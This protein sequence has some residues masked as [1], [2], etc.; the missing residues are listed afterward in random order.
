MRY[1]TATF[2]LLKKVNSKD[3]L[4]E[5]FFT[6]LYRILYPNTRMWVIADRL[7]ICPG[8]KVRN[9]SRRTGERVIN[10]KFLSLEAQAGRL[11]YRAHYSRFFIERGE[12]PNYKKVDDWHTYV[13]FDEVH[14]EE[15]L[16]DTHEGKPSNEPRSPL[17]Q[18]ESKWQSWLRE[19][20]LI[21]LKQYVIQKNG[22]HKNY[23]VMSHEFEVKLEQFIRGRNTL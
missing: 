7:Q 11:L 1:S 15:F 19:T 21:M 17:Y 18:Q 20:H 3:Q 4:D 16:V 10:K 5:E 23:D 12:F 9:L 22:F 13:P 6:L 8:H 14:R 2:K